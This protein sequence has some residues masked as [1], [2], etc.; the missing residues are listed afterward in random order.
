MLARLVGN[1]MFSSEITYT[2]NSQLQPL[3]TLLNSILFLS[4]MRAHALYK[5]ETLASWMTDVTYF[6]IRVPVEVK[7]R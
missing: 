3:W 1:F 2:R 7:T 5:K 4:L 6:G